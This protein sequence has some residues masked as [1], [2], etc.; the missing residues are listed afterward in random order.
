[1]IGKGDSNHWVPL[2]GPA[3]F[4]GKEA[5]TKP[6]ELVLIALGGCTGMDVIS[7]LKKMRVNYEELDI[8]ISATRKEE[9]P[10]IFESIHIKY[11]IKGKEVEENKFKKAI[12]KSQNKYCSVSAILKQSAEVTYEYEIV[13]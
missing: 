6:M 4:G 9:H 8:E 1:M 10:K 13:E 3:D 2:D 12:E 5:A 11:K 7:I